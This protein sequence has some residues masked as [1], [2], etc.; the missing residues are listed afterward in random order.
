MNMAMA[1][2]A[3][4]QSI[5]VVTPWFPN[6]PGEQNAAYIFDSA[7]ALARTGAKVSVLVC[8]PF[9]PRALARFAPEWMRGEIDTA[10][11]NGQLNEVVVARYPALPGGL[12]RPLSNAF[13]R[14]AVA[15]A[16]RRLVR[17]TNANVIHA[18]TEGM[19]PI[20]LEV[21]RATQIPVVATIHGLNTDT[22]YLNAKAQRALLAPALRDVDRLVLVGEPLR[23]VFETYTGRGDHIRIVA[24][25]VRMPG[26]SVAQRFGAGPLRLVSVSNLHE[27][28][29][30]DIT[31][32]ALAE[33][34]S[35]GLTN[36]TYTIVGGGAERERLEAQMRTLGLADRVTFLG[37]KSQEEVFAALDRSDVFVLPSYREAFGI[38]YLEA[39]ASG[40]VA[41]GVEGQGPSAFIENART[42]FLVAPRSSGAVAACLRSIAENPAEARAI[43][44]RAR[45]AAQAF[46]WSAHADRLMSV[47][48]ET[49]AVPA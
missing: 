10:S 12:L 33:L 31:L 18:Q 23:G 20:A 22:N 11:F 45:A 27:G 3:S 30:V 36:W 38:A 19:A 13:Q 42:G 5:V 28:K 29:G 26:A 25:G 40:L 49:V 2:T 43:G 46:T 4:A 17:E 8:R 7:A 34:R 37:P 44:E 39:M 41:I 15:R 47:F 21:A 14:R 1:R 35:A 48:A 9:V 6:R 16:L 32:E 24:N